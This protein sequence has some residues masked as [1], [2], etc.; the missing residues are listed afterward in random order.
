MTSPSRTVSVRDIQEPAYQRK[1]GVYTHG[2]LSISSQYSIGFRSTSWF[3]AVLLLIFPPVLLT[4]AALSSPFRPVLDA[5]EI[6]PQQYQ[7]IPGALLVLQAYVALLSLCAAHIA[8]PR[9]F[10][11]SQFFLFEKIRYHR[12]HSSHIRLNRFRRL[13]DD[14][15]MTIFVRGAQRRTIPIL[16]GKHSTVDYVLD[17]LRK[18]GHIPRNSQ[19]SHSLYMPGR[20]RRLL[21]SLTMADLNAGSLSHFDIRVRVLGGASGSNNASSS[22][23]PGTDGTSDANDE[24]RPQ[25]NKTNPLMAEYLEAEGQ[26]EYGNPIPAKPARRRVRH[27]Q[28]HKVSDNPPGKGKRKGKEKAKASKESGAEGSTDDDDPDFNSSQSSDSESSSS[29]EVEILNDELADSLPSKTIPTRP[30]GSAPKR[31]LGRNGE[32]PP[33]KKPH[34]SNSA[35]DPTSSSTPS[36]SATPSA[37]APAAKKFRRRGKRNP[38][39]LF[40][41]EVDK[42]SSGSP[43]QPGDKHYKCH[44]G[45]HHIL[46]VTE[47]MRFSVNGLTGYLK[48]HA[49]PMY[50]LYEILFQRSKEDPDVT[51]RS[52]L[53]TEEEIEIAAGKRTFDDVAEQS[54][55]A[56]LRRL[57]PNTIG[58]AFDRQRTKNTLPWDQERFERL[59][60]EWIVSCDQPFDE[61]DKAEF[62]ELLF[63]THRSSDL[64]I[65]GRKAIRERIMAMEKGVKEKMKKMFSELKSRVSISLDAW[66]SS[67]GL[68]RA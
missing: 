44:H 60:A 59:L 12:S 31:K 43:G 27:P 41:E 48:T 34:R 15:M 54:Y 63:C 26:D 25:R 52:N 22:T 20:L 3:L 65:P 4:F 58:E 64:H 53:P 50:R 14:G 10:D 46:T 40:F 39:Y 17:T 24:G 5:L 8:F 6:S 49:P 47:G 13:V 35:S 67:N 37:P 19:E 57:Q 30:G 9:F 7:Y 2:V 62:R 66:T 45:D 1:S 55:L 51:G 23:L 36:T 42:N 68:R 11:L 61:V 21:G 33:R 28:N 32:Q 18:R 38:A 16:V 56:N 29:D